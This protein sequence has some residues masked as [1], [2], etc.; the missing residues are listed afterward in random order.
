VGIVCG[1]SLS[2]DRPGGSSCTST[3][4][5][6]SISV[7]NS[8]SGMMSQPEAFASSAPRALLLCEP[9][10]PECAAA[11]VAEHACTCD[12]ESCWPVRTIIRKDLQPCARS[13]LACLEDMTS[14][15]R[16][17]S[18]HGDNKCSQR[19]FC[20]GCKTTRSP[21]MMPTPST[22]VWSTYA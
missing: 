3:S 15:L 22:R 8:C 10:D 4:L 21:Q 20:N 13:L 17:A 18:A 6:S 12:A 1:T 11:A 16:S 5:N 19:V 2:G 14:S 9:E 7:R